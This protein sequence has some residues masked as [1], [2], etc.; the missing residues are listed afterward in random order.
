MRR[1]ELK[2]LLSALALMTNNR[3]D[4]IPVVDADQTLIG[5]VTLENLLRSESVHQT[6]E[7][8]DLLKNAGEASMAAFITTDTYLEVDSERPPFVLAKEIAK[9]Q[10]LRAYLV[11]DHRLCGI[12]TLPDLLNKCWKKE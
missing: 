7:M 10:R 2:D 12:A 8:E 9:H 6:E 1:I 4:S 3:I 5:E 11:K